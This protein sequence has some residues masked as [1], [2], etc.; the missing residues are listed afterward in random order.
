M[1]GRP[2]FCM[3]YAWKVNRMKIEPKYGHSDIVSAYSLYLVFE[4]INDVKNV[5]RMKDDKQATSFRNC[6]SDRLF[7][8]PIPDLQDFLKMN[9]W[10]MCL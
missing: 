10:F 6:F 4:K 7:Q 3:R 5:F 2:I 8:W 9:V 1:R